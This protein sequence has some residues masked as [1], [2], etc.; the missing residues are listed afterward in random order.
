M[1]DSQTPDVEETPEP[2][3]PQTR[4]ES[5]QA[6]IEASR[7]Q[8]RDDAGKFAG[9]AV[10]EPEVQPEPEKPARKLPSSWRKE[11]E[12]IY[13]TL[14]DEAIQEIERRESDYFKG[15]E[16]YKQ[17]AAKWQEFEQALTPYQ[18]AL[19]ASGKQPMELVNNLLSSH[20]ALTFGTP[21]QKAQR[22]Q[23]LA[24][25][26]GVSL[27]GA[28]QANPAHQ[29]IVTL[30]REIEEF[31]KAQAEQ[32]EASAMAEI[33]A[34][35][36]DKPHFEAVR[37]E[38]ASALQ[39]NPSRTLEQAYEAACWANPDIRSQLL[40]EQQK[41]AEAERKA[42]A[43]EA[44]RKAKSAS[45]SVNGAPMTSGTLKADPSDRRAAIAQAMQSIRH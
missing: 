18:A 17:T 4:R 5:L 19:Q 12:P 32:S 33:Q 42:K 2:E 30:K 31:K 26:Y 23:Q 44:A 7:G 14:P 39:S 41:Q 43:A 6:A 45:A 34:F 9:E 16:P 40:Q 36:K 10:D 27:N 1:D 13:Q 28:P 3:A 11:L 15:L 38:M 25:A 8:P 35:A 21:E 22:F 29:D 37:A 24:E 20:A